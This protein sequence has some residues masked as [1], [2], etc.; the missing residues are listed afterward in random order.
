M[1]FNEKSKCTLH[2]LYFA[3][4]HDH[5]IPLFLKANVL[6][7]TFLYYGLA[8]ALMHDINNDKAQVNVSNLFQKTSN[9]HS[10]NSQS[11]KSGKFD[12]KSSRLEMQNNYFLGLE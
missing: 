7:M 9:I 2:L 3:D 6:P 11:Y 12:V 5:A 8:S 4:W 1:R 10:Y